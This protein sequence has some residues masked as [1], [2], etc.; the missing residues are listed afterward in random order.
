[1]DAHA[2]LHQLAHAK[3][4][5]FEALV[6]AGAHREELTPLFLAE[7]ESWTAATP[8][9]RVA[10]APRTGSML[11]IVHLLAEWGESRAY[12]PVVRLLRLPPDDVGAALGDALTVTTSRVLASLFDGDPEP[13]F[14][15]ALDPGADE[16]ARGSALECLASAAVEGR[17][18]REAVVRFLRE[19]PTALQPKDECYAWVAWLEAVALLGLEDLAPNVR[20]AFDRGWADETWLDYADFE[21]DL[22]HA[23]AHPEAPWGELEQVLPW[24]DTAAAFATWSFGD[25]DDLGD[26]DAW[27]DDLS[28]EELMAWAAERDPI[29]LAM[30][31][32][33][34]GRNAGDDP[35]TW[36]LP[37]E[38][39][40]NPHRHVGRNDPCPCGSGK[41]YKKCCLA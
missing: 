16:F 17:L 29:Q 31:G 24:A 15:L 26:D 28:D 23:L 25:D 21:R 20:E 30:L 9:E 2:I 37:G 38:P 19:A 32:E 1:M 7:I 5:P 12:R 36:A 22:R 3:E 14:A 33:V 18:E 13:L 27:D 4:I 40:V 35:P 39:V 41:K 34:L 6:C 8:E 11:F 10:D